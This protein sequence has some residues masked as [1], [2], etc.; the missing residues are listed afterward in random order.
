MNIDELLNRPSPQI[1]TIEECQ[2]IV[3][4]Y[5]EKATNRKVKINIYSK[6]GDPYNLNPFGVFTVQMEIKKLWTAFLIASERYY[7][8]QNSN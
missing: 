2:F 7:G 4:K 5:I 3:E 8:I 1:Y 6:I